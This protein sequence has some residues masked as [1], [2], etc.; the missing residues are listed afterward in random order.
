M[1][2]SFLRF[3]LVLCFLFD[4]QL[5]L[6]EYLLCFDP[7]LGCLVRQILNRAHILQI[8]IEMKDQQVGNQ[9]SK[10]RIDNT[11]ETAHYSL[12]IEILE[13]NFEVKYYDRDYVDDQVEESRNNHSNK[14][15]IVSA[16]DTIV[17]PFAV[18]IELFS[19]SQS[20]K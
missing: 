2:F 12:G 16:S 4:I 14:I 8:Q 5:S 19:T 9:N 10:D 6:R 18:M 20:H 7:L 11:Y 3:I 1:V 17:D 15:T 13:I